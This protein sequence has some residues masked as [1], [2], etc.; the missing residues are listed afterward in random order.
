MSSHP[1]SAS[2]VTSQLILVLSPKTA[3]IGTK[4]WWLTRLSSVY[5]LA[6]TPGEGGF[7][8][9]AIKA[10]HCSCHW[11]L[12]A[13]CRL[14]ATTCENILRVYL[15]DCSWANGERFICSHSSIPFILFKRIKGTFSCTTLHFPKHRE[16]IHG[17]NTAF[18]FEFYPYQARHR[19]FWL[20]V[21]AM[22]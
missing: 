1:H 2:W 5:Y 21:S 15:E 18:S 16:R 8:V 3:L 9:V 10:H 17:I 14:W 22:T 12:S 19:Y 4:F 7:L 20:K 6:Q 13:L 11:A